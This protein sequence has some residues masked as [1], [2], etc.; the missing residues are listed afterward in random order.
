MKNNVITVVVTYNRRELL[1]KGLE[2][3][4]SQTHPCD[5]LVV[6]NA[7]DDGTKEMIDNDFD[8]PEVIYMNTGSNL[9]CSGGNQVGIKKALQLGY[10]YVW[11]MDDDTWP[12]KYALEQLFKADKKINGNWG[13]LSS[14]AYWTDGNICKMN[15][16]KKDIFR[17]VKEKDYQ[18]SIVKIHMATFVSLLVKSDVIKEVGLPIGEYFI[19]TDDWEFTGRIS[20][21]GYQGYMVSDSRVVHAMKQNARVNFATEEESRIERFHYIYRNDVNCY[22]NYGLK[23][24]MYLISKGVYTALNILLHSEGNKTQKIR[25][26]IKGF[27]EGLKFNPAIEKV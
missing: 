12:E 3:L 22:R 8:R 7:S 1:R 10:D 9:G 15:W 16:Q 14:V 11:I 13:F 24:W 6:D 25:I 21:A 4:L 19:W 23:G 2:S 18:H 20:R 17:H 26:M 27:A 5:V